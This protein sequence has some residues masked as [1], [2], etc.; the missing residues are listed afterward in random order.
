MIEKGLML[1]LALVGGSVL[2]APQV[3]PEMMAK[4]KQLSPAQ[5]QALAAQYGI[6]SS[7]L[8]ASSTKSSVTPVNTAPVAV[9]RDVDYSQ[10]SQR[11]LLAGVAQDGELQPFGYNVF[12]YRIFSANQLK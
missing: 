9:P 3:T 5:Q 6:D 7:Q 10:P 4:F 2:A 12:M 8:G 11:P 1:S